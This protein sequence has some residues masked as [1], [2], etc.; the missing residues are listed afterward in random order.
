MV[1]PRSKQTKKIG[2]SDSDIEMLASSLADKPYGRA[3]LPS[4][5]STV[6]QNE[7]IERIT[8]S[9]PASLRLKLEDTALMRKRAGEKNKNVSAIIRE[10]LEA[11]FL[12]I[13]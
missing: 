4:E 12:K 6:T 2:A 7:S 11:F 9:I 13:D 1:K 5:L 8:I 10:S 3:S